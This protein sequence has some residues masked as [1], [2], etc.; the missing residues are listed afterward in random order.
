[1]VDLSR[2]LTLCEYQLLLRDHLLTLPQLDRVRA[3][4]ELG[5]PAGRAGF[6]VIGSVDDQPASWHVRGEPALD[7]LKLRFQYGWDIY[8][9]VSFIIRKTRGDWPQGESSA[10]GKPDYEG[11]A[12]QPGPQ[13]CP[14]TLSRAFPGDRGWSYFLGRHPRRRQP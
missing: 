10:K 6:A 7:K 13:P 11:H 8:D 2:S 12:P 3:R 5:L 9:R 1:M 14:G 4:G